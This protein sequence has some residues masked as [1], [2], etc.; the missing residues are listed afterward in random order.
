MAQEHYTPDKFEQTMIDGFYNLHLGLDR[1]GKPMGVR[2]EFIFLPMMRNL[3]ETSLGAPIEEFTVNDTQF[4]RVII[5]DAH[6]LV[7]IHANVSRSIAETLQIKRQIYID[8]TGVTP[9]RF[10]LAVGS[11]HSRRANAL[12]EAGFEVIEPE[13]EE[14]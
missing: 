9:A 14:V 11:I 5:G 7:E 13:E 2:N 4:T 10:I 6:I 8:A 1:L 3:I 12:R